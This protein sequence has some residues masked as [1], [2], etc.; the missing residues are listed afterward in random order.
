MTLSLKSN[1]LCVL[2]SLRKPLLA[3]LFVKKT[4]SVNQSSPEEAPDVPGNQADTSIQTRLIHSEELL[5]GHTE[6]LIRHGSEVYRLRV[7]RSG[8]L[9]LTK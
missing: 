7:T 4:Q 2:A 9:I 6:I 8:K 3:F 5:S 1:T